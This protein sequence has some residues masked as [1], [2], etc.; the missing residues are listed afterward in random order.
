MAKAPA[1]GADDA[2]AAEDAEAAATPV[3]MPAKGLSEGDHVLVDDPDDESTQ[4]EAV[5][6][7][8]DT[9]TDEDRILIDF[10]T[11]AGTGGQLDLDPDDE[12]PLAA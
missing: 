5:V 7:Q 10:R 3:M 6:E 2:A 8:I 12:L 9:E 4:V 1:A 11:A